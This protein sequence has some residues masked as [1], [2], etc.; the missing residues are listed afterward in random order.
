MKNY[1]LAAGFLTLSLTACKQSETKVLTS[2]N[3]DGSVTTTTVETEKTTDY[4]GL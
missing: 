2:E 4:R 3:P 1:L